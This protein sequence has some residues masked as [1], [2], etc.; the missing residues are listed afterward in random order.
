MQNLIYLL[1]RR[2]RAPLIVVICAYAISIT[3]FV[4]IP[5]MD[6]QGQP[7]R[8]GFFHAF[9]FVSFMGSTIGFGEIPYPFTDAQ[10]LW[11]IIAIYMTVISWLYAIGV[12]LA[13][14]QDPVVR[15]LIRHTGF[16]RDVGRIAEP[17]YLI[18]G[19][20]DTGHLLVQALADAGIRSV[21]DD[22]DEQ[23]INTLELEDLGLDVPGIRGDAADPQVLLRAGLRH[24]RCAGVIALTDDDHVNL[25][26]AITATLLV[27][28]LSIVARAE[29]RAGEENIQSLGEIE[30]INPF[31]TFA[32][33]LAMALHSPGTYVLYEW[34][35]GVPHERLPMP[36]YPPGGKWILCGYGRFGKAVYRR[37]IEEGV[38]VQVI[39]AN[40]ELTHPP[41]DAVIG[42]GA[43]AAT[44]L[45]AGVEQ[46]A[47]IVAGTDNDANNLSIL[48]TARDINPKLF[49]V[50]RQNARTNRDLF[51]A[52]RFDL[53]MQRGSVI[54]HKIFALIT[55]PLLAEFLELAREQ[56]NAWAN[57]LVARIGGVVADEAPESWMLPL[58]AMDAPALYATLAEG[59]D[60]RIGDLLC[61]PRFREQRLACVPLLIM[62]DSGPVLVPDEDE[63]VKQEDRILFCGRT[64]AFQE[65]TWIARNPDVLR[66]VC[67]GEEHPSTVLGRLLSAGKS[68]DTG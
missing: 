43:D 47:G 64:E 7:W 23:R 14:L 58:N 42:L 17:F 16:R 60:I 46:A 8:M 24:P 48:I 52:A 68:Q 62:R 6:D 67:T 21:V 66:Y 27:P 61:H 19:Y 9:Y 36:L 11:T 13:T 63:S 3:G 32:G 25:T 22:I 35:T 44:L 56:T 20:G 57:E 45:Q 4:L 34:L 33:R 53:V 31:E 12:T 28:G 40:E 41:Q 55:T 10:R 5:G 59:R 15:R 50:A 65:M 29:T 1:L 54:A 49:T 30:T 2:L 51:R 37:L 38:E 18:C 39:E 26:V